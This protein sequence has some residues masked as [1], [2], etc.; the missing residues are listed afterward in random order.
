M[1]FS[2][3]MSRLD[4]AALWHK[5]NNTGMR[6]VPLF[7]Y[8][9]INQAARHFLGLLLQKLIY[10]YILPE[11][12]AGKHLSETPSSL[13]LVFVCCW[14]NRKSQ[15]QRPGLSGGLRGPGAT[16]QGGG[17]KVDQW[18]T[19]AKTCVPHL[20]MF[21]RKN[22]RSSRNLQVGNRIVVCVCVCVI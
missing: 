17:G 5:L 14:K 20:L 3:C 2:I 11:D 13:C 12:K 1:P 7:A 21:V 8:E 19:S 16:L 18:P 22:P 6:T 10:M 4:T 15:C 9:R